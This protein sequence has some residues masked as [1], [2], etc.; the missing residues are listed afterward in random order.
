MNA[1]GW[2]R[3]GKS[4]ARSVEHL[5]LREQQDILIDWAS[6]A[7]MEPKW[8]KEIMRKISRMDKHL[9][10][11]EFDAFIEELAKLKLGIGVTI[12]EVEA[13]VA[14]T[15]RIKEAKDVMEAG[16]S[17][18]GYDTAVAALEAYQKKILAE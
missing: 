6:N 15:D 4:N 11:A 10:D 13:I 8:R 14:L 7:E 9:S 5:S 17:R 12:E 2:L 1:F 18:N 16:G 3:G